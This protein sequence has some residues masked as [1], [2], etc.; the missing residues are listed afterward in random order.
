MWKGEKKTV[1]VIRYHRGKGEGGGE[2]GGGGGGG[3]VAFGDDSTY[4]ADVV[5]GW[6]GTREGGG[7][8]EGGDGG[9]GEDPAALFVRGVAVVVRGWEAEV[10][11][12][13]WSCRSLRHVQLTY[14]VAPPFNTNPRMPPF[15]AA[16]ILFSWFSI[17]FLD[18]IAEENY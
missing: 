18:F 4:G 15:S 11:G 5:R 9:A 16:N 14:T 3:V 7:G 2:G 8:G 13:C 12:S 10:E 6:G 17:C 1:P